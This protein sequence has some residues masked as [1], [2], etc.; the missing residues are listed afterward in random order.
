[1]YGM[2][3]FNVRGIDKVTCVVLLTAIAHNL[4]RW[5]ALVG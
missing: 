3:Q 5:I 4:L 2:R 1:M